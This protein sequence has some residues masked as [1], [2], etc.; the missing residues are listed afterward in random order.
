MFATSQ[1]R[2][3][4]AALTTANDTLADALANATLMLDAQACVLDVVPQPGAAEGITLG[5][6]MTQ[7]DARQFTAWLHGKL[8]QQRAGGWAAIG[9]P[10]EQWPASVRR[11]G[12]SNDGEAIALHVGDRAGSL[13]WI[14]FLNS[15][16][17][18]E[19]PPLALPRT[20]AAFTN[21]LALQLRTELAVRAVSE[22]RDQLE[23]IFRFSGDG[24]LTV[25]A[26]L[27]ITA[28]NPALEHL[29][30]WNVATIIG[31]FYYD[32]LRL[33][34]HNGE[35]LG[36]THCPLLEAF[37][38]G[39]PVL[40]E[41]VIHARDGQPIDVA[42]TASAVRSPEGLPTSGVLNVR[43]VSRSR[44][45][46]MLSSTIVSV[47]SHELQTPIA[48]IKGYAST[49]SR[50]DAIWSGEPL[51]QRLH[52][53]EE[54]ADRL[55][56]MVA[57]L[58][59][60]SR[61]QAG[62]LSMQP[63]PIEISAVLTSAVRRFRARSPHHELRLHMPANLPIVIADNERIEEVIANLL[64]N[65]IK[66]S[67]PGTSVMVEGRFNS[68]YVII[69]VSDSGAGIPLREQQ[70]V[71]DRFQRVEGDLTRQTT[72]AGL[73]LYIC[74]AIVTAHTGQIWVES[75]VGHGSRFSFSLPRVER[76]AVP[77]VILPER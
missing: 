68:E 47:V 39:T 38:T 77:M 14:I 25:D 61:I 54:E 58:L 74:Q 50:P 32:V 52:A 73:G 18:M 69:S 71:F 31:K 8:D 76:A 51:R 40:R 34:D 53:I 67:K 44:E 37:A 28:C 60:A 26:T 48:I 19:R 65:A 10:A 33:E 42:V 24:I 49:L 43:D 16:G 56:H 15:P 1:P 4:I 22:Q 46:E 20:R 35:A 13:G 3:K 5:G 66:Y 21:Q 62:G 17:A 6:G 64:D 36:L 7:P 12:G 27:R 57:N 41:V 29:T 11:L 2:A 55:S 9:V 72:G 70:R 23:S 59:Y 75:E 30:G 63:A 45:N